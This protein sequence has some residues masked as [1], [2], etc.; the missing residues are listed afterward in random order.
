M[1][2]GSKK[3]FTYPCNEFTRK[4]IHICTLTFVYLKS[5]T[6]FL[7][8]MQNVEWKMQNVECMRGCISFIVQ[9][10]ARNITTPVIWLFVTNG[11]NE[12]F[13]HFHQ[14]VNLPCG[15]WC[16]SPVTVLFHSHVISSLIFSLYLYG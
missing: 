3:E 1:R 4:Y 7:A 16:N 13:R 2:E 8:K 15:N 10:P 9:T 14:R 12:D 5:C 6:N 11:F